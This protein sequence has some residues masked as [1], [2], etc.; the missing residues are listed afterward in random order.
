MRLTI[1]FALTLAAVILSTASAV[2]TPAVAQEED[3]NK[4]IAA[5]K[6]EGKVVVYNSALGAP[7]YS[8]VVKAFE[9]KYGIKVETLDLRAS[10]LSERIRAE[11]SAGRFLGDLEQHSTATIERQ[12]REIGS[13]QPHGYIP[14][15]KNLR[16]PFVATEMIVPAWVQAYG[17]L[18]N[19]KLVKPADEPKNWHDLLDPK[20]KGKILSDDTRA[21]G[22]GNTMASVTY[23]KYGEAFERQLADQNLVFSRELRADARRTARGEYPIYIPQMFALASDL[24]GLPVKV[25]VP[26]DGSPYVPINNAMLKNAPHPNAAR[27]FMNHFL[28][29]DSQL[30]YANA[31]MVPVVEGVIEKADPEARRLVST[32]L[33]GATPWERQQELMDLAIKIF[34]R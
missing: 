17:I 18:V 3:W 22:G 9:Q 1:S 4:V 32:K 5:A 19:T 10:E 24:K 29:I 27:V 14:N 25:I 23:L 7:Y 15:A 11:Q 33:M 6:Q 34:T 31:W 12:I 16:E 30:T 8:T 20:W 2:L 21:L 28:E 26:E 13:V